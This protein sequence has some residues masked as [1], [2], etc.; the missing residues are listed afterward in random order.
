MLYKKYLTTYK[1]ETRHCLAKKFRYIYVEAVRFRLIFSLSPEKMFLTLNTDIL[2]TKLWNDFHAI[3]GW[4]SL[5]SLAFII[6]F[7][8]TRDI[9]WMSE[10]VSG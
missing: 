6:I 8:L 10:R 2:R 3:F 9:E 5:G 7:P 1:A 4:N